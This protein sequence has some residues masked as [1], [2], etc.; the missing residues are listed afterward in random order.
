MISDLICLSS[1]IPL[2]LTSNVV[3]LFPYCYYFS[4][5]VSADRCLQF[6]DIGVCSALFQSVFFSLFNRN[7]AICPGCFSL[8]QFFLSFR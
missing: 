7:K 4:H 5:C 6:L 3:D 2:F 1:Y 8:R